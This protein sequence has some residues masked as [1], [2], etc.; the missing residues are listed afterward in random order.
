[1]SNGLKIGSLKMHTLFHCIP[2]KFERVHLRMAKPETPSKPK[3]TLDQLKVI[4]IEEE[5]MLNSI[6]EK[7]DLQN[8]TVKIANFA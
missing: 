2:R 6:N 4:I 5:L 3:P 1:M 8:E 7:K